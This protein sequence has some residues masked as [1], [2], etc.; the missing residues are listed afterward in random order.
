M[1]S[2]RISAYV[3]PASAKLT[4]EDGFVTAF[5]K[6]LITLSVA[7]RAIPSNTRRAVTEVVPVPEPATDDTLALVF[8]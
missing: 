1:S 6:N 5:W 7:S 4:V 3:N 8:V 2:T